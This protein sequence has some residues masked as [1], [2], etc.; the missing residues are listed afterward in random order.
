VQSGLMVT[1]PI[2]LFFVAF[3]GECLLTLKL[4]VMKI[5]GFGGSNSSKSINREL[6]R[7][8]ASYFQE[9]DLEILDLNDYE[10]PIYKMD[11]ERDNGIPRLAFDFARKIDD[12]DLLIVSLAENN[13]AYS[14]A[15]KNI[16]DWVSRIAGRKV[17]ADKPML[18]MATSPG[19]RGG[20]SVLEIAKNRMPRSG[21]NVLET[22]SL[23]NFYENFEVGKG[24]TNVELKMQL[25]S[26]I[27]S[28]KA[29][30]NP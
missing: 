4:L 2:I 17:F 30:F 9:H 28:V 3:H 24:I 10:M 11:R 6:V 22:F 8:A 25:E 14:T 16:F 21:G 19:A 1:E 20:A 7:F 27:E 29:H 12:C 23:P 15:F 26:K 5:L 18:L 13:G